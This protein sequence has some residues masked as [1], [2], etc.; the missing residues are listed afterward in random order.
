M[1]ARLVERM[2]CVERMSHSIQEK[3][4]KDESFFQEIYSLRHAA[5]E[6]Y[7]FYYLIDENMCEEDYFYSLLQIKEPIY[8]VRSW[9]YH[10]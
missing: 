5:H 4:E 9:D 3:L 6:K 7:G 1:K 8:F 2:K 10:C